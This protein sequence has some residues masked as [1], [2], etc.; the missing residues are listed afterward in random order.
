MTAKDILDTIEGLSH[1]QGFYSR[2]YEYIMRLRDNSPENYTNY[3]KDLESHNF[4][5]S[6]DLIM[7]LAT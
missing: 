6:V 2:L 5:N 7:Y 1:S 3:M 4:K